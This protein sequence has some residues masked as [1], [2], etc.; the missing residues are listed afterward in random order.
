MLAGMAETANDLGDY[1]RARRGRL[2]PTDLG[3]PASRH[4]R[5]PGLRREEVASLAGVSVD[6]VIRLEQGKADRP[7]AEVVDALAGA[8]RLDRDGHRHLRLLAG[9]APPPLP[10]ARP[11][12]PP[13]LL[14]MLEALEPAAAL[15][16]NAA[17]DLLA[18][19]AAARAILGPLGDERP[20]EDGPPNSARRTFLDPAARAYMPAW[21]DKAPLMVANMREAR[22]PDRPDPAL[23]A[24][25]D[26]L[27]A[28]S[29]EFR[30]MWDDHEVQPCL[31]GLKHYRHPAVGEFRVA[32]ETLQTSVPGIVLVLYRP[33]ADDERSRTAYDLLTR[34]HLSA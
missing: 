5:T 19:T 20:G 28:A 11:G 2:D 34:V 17:T 30:R 22:R 23:D 15:L 14:A 7:S 6:Y 31:N 29:P 8:L 24:V 1:L 3:L 12:V 32:Y 10:P 16:T 18:A 4:R 27:R 26:E 21:E 33:L 25:V 13:G 9:M